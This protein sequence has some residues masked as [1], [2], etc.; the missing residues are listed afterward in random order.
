[1]QLLLVVIILLFLTFVPKLVSVSLLRRKTNVHTHTWLWHNVSCSPDST[2]W[3][4]MNA[5]KLRLEMNLTSIC[6][7]KSWHNSVMKNT[8]S[9]AL[10]MSALGKC[11][12]LSYVN[13]LLLCSLLKLHLDNWEVNDH[14][15]ASCESHLVPYLSAFWIST[16]YKAATPAFPLL[17]QRFL[18]LRKGVVWW[19]GELTWTHFTVP[20]TH[21]ALP[22]CLAIY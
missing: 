3:I 12:I 21:W 17:I 8:W 2:E 13:W 15:W 5:S 20:Y 1:M 9:N 7:F 14:L 10:F 16:S 6:K 4:K 22:M 19:A 11:S 18:E